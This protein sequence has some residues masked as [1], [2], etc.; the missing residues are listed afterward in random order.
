MD[1]DK[2]K[3][4]LTA[5]YKPDLAAPI[6]KR[7]DEDKVAAVLALMEPKDAA[8]YSEALAK[9]ASKP[10]PAPPTP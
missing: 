5:E 2:V 8:A 6:L 4:I 3:S 9:E 1:P 7:M 10:P